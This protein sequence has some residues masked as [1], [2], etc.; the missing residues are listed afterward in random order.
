MLNWLSHPGAPATYVNITSKEVISR[1][2]GSGL[3]CS[4]WLL[5]Q[6]LGIETLLPVD[7]TWRFW[8]PLP[9]PPK[10][11]HTHRLAENFTDSTD[12]LKP[13]A[14]NPGLVPGKMCRHGPHARNTSVEKRC[15]QVSTSGVGG[16]C[17][18][19]LQNTHLTSVRAFPR[20]AEMGYSPRWDLAITWNYFPWIIGFFW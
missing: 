9:P 8:W 4:L 15:L 14:K 5:E 1:S 6:S 7:V 16:W 11:I 12:L 19:V 20:K 18:A 10:I 3:N 13:T 2:Q 17:S